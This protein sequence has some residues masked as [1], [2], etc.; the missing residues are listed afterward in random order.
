MEENINNVNSKG[1]KKKIISIIVVVLV[2]AVLALGSYFVF[3]KNK[4]E[5]PAN[6][7]AI[8]AT[9]NGTIIPKAVYDAQLAK[10]I[11]TYKEQGVDVAD[12]A[13]L[14]QIKTQV[15]DNLIADE[16]VN[17][18]IVAAGIKITPEEVEKQFQTVLTQTGGADKLQAELIKN[19]LTEAQLRENISRQ[20]TIQEYLSQNID[21]ASVTASEAEIAQFYADYSKA[22]KAADTKVVVPALKELSDQIKQ[23][24]IADKQQT[25]VTNFIASLRSKATVEITP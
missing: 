3:G 19:N 15:L 7:A 24:I 5:V 25:L 16:L 10:S 1:G 18:G 20:L 14:A 8:A 23:Q 11:A 21:L 4:I 6:N 17:Q 13:K 22:Q 2:L 12:P 9:V